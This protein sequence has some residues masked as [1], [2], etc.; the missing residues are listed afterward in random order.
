MKPLL[1][2][3][4]SHL[5]HGQRRSGMCKKGAHYSLDAFSLCI[6]QESG[7]QELKTK[8]NS[9]TRFE[10]HFRLEPSPRSMSVAMSECPN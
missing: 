7:K 8:Q 9:A 10:E 5:F 2:R 1:S 4:E 3:R 6:H